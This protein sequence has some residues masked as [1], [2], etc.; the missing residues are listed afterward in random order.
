MGEA[1]HTPCHSAVIEGGVNSIAEER[2][3]LAG[4]C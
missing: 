3:R 2:S 4:L 1:H